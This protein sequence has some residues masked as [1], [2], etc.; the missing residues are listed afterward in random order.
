MRSS[1][2]QSM[3]SN[4]CVEI[5]PSAQ[6]YGEG[7]PRGS[8]KLPAL[9]AAQRAREEADEQRKRSGLLRDKPPIQNHVLELGVKIP[10]KKVEA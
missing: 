7:P 2:R 9:L 1:R 10:D 3:S 5:P 4:T 6:P 8:A